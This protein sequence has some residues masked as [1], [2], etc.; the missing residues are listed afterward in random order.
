MRKK[1]INEKAMS[2]AL[3]SMGI[4]FLSVLIRGGIVNSITV[5]TLWQAVIV[6]FILTVFLLYLVPIALLLLLFRD[7]ISD[8]YI[9][10]EDKFLWLKYALDLFLVGEIVRLIICLIP[11]GTMSTTIIFGLPGRMLFD[12][13]YGV[14]A[15]RTWEV[16]VENGTTFLDYF[17]YLLCYIVAMAPYWSA[18][19]IG[20]RYFWMHAH[21]IKTK[22]NRKEFL[23]NL[24]KVE[25]K[26]EKKKKTETIK[27]PRPKNKYSGVIKSILQHSIYVFVEFLIIGMASNVVTLLFGTLFSFLG[28]K[29]GITAANSRELWLIL[30][31]LCTVVCVLTCIFFSR[32]IG[33]SAADGRYSRSGKYDIFVPEVVSSI[34][35]GSL[36]YAL[37]CFI[38]SWPSMS[39][40]FIAGPVPYIARYISNKEP[41]FFGED[42]LSFSLAVTISS[43]LIFTM[44]LAAGSVLGYVNGYHKRMEDIREGERTRSAD[45][46]V[47]DNVSNIKRNEREASELTETLPKKDEIIYRDKFDC[48]TEAWY[49]ELN[50]KRK[51]LFIG[52][53][54]LLWALDLIV[55][56]IWSVKSGN[57]FLSPSAIFFTTILVLPFWPFALHDKI[58]GNTY[59]AEVVKMRVDTVTEFHARGRRLGTKMG[60]K[61]VD[62]L[63]L[64]GDDGVSFE[65]KLPKRCNTKYE[66]GEKVFKLSTYPY[67]VKCTI[68]SVVVCPKC[69]N[70]VNKKQKKCNNCSTPIP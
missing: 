57:D 64:K 13:T 22:N 56:I 40:L 50:K 70:E 37:V 17:V 48:K 58:I 68:S 46:L 18:L 32:F 5:G 9:Q 4:T 29:Y 47:S 51:I 26:N 30:A 12:V 45:K 36:V 65:L 38:M 67:P 34:G 44:I 28:T 43:V 54:L 15:G 59:Y 11:D 49:R 10:T 66:E 23:E 24:K 41:D 19:L 55:W 6:D 25:K 52:L 2:Y 20:Y 39:R 21:R 53:T 1:R 27:I 7:K 14:V 62:V 61:K 8:T 69:S 3:W 63:V 33:Q 31:L 35:C 60:T 16:F 42:A